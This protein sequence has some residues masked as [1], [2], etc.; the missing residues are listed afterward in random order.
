MPVPVP[1]GNVDELRAFLA[2]DEDYEATERTFVLTVAWLVAA[3]W[4]RGPYPVAVLQGEQG[5]GKSTRSRLLRELVDPNAAP[6]RS[7]PREERDLVIAAKNSA[8]LSYDNLSHVPPWLSDGLCRLA[9]GG[10]FATRQLYTDAEE[11]LFQ[12]SRPTLLNG[13][14]DLVSR[15]DLASRAIVFRLPPLGVVEP[16]HQYWARFREAHPR[17]LGALLDGLVAA[18]ANRDRLVDDPP[19]MADFANLV[20]RA[21]PAFGWEDGTFVGHYREAIDAL[22]RDELAVEPVAVAI[23][24]FLATPFEIT[25]K[26]SGFSLTDGV[27]SARASDWLAALETTGE[28]DGRRTPTGWPNGPRALSNRLARLAPALRQVGI[29]VDRGRSGD[30]RRITAWREAE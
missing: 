6:L 21:E 2:V 7:Q 20:H 27:L 9:T 15:P 28:A 19:R 10:G 17:I 25:Q 16:E 26:H 1:G 11:V 14:P 18:L 3:L 13:I 24:E 12:S 5:S 29:Y 8:L 23:A 30:A 22:V 4:G